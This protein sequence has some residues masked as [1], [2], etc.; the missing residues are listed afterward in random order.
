MKLLNKS[1]LEQIKHAT[2]KLF[3]FGQ[4]ILISLS[5]PVLYYTGV[6]HSN[7]KKSDETIIRT[8]KGKI[9]KKIDAGV[10]R[11]QQTNIGKA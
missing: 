8:N 2:G 6:T 9:I 5:L 1:S 11:V 4:V 7:T 10:L 3:F